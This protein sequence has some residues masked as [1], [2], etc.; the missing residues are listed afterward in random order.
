MKPKLLKSS[1]ELLKFHNPKTDKYDK[2]QQLIFN[3][4]PH[5]LSNRFSFVSKG[6]FLPLRKS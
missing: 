4:F 5:S 2:Q 1:L 3:F 6:F